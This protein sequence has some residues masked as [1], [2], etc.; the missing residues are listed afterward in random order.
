MSPLTA[1]TST[2]AKSD[3][4]TSALAGGAEKN[5]EP[6]SSAVTATVTTLSNLRKEASGGRVDQLTFFTAS[7]IVI[8]AGKGGVGKTTVSAGLAMA[9]AQIGLRVL[10]VELDE[11]PGA[12][13]IFGCSTP[14]GYG[15]TEI[16]LI[17]PQYG[18]GHIWAQRITASDA[19]TDYLDNHG[20]GR[21][22]RRL[23]SSGIVDIV[24]TAAPGIDDLLVLGKIKALE[25]EG[26]AD[27][28]VVDGPAAGHAISMLMAPRALH[29]SVSGGPIHQQAQEILELLG[30]ESRCQVMLVTL[31]ETTPVSELI[32]TA[33]ALEDEVG[34][35]LAPLVINS[36]EEH[37]VLTIPESLDPKSGLVLAAQF[38]NS[39]VRL[40][41]QEITRLAESI[42]LPTL[43]LPFFSSTRCDVIAAS[44]LHQI[45]LLP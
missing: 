10:F 41:T 8:V 12:E 7:R 32:D 4:E 22:R 39:R 11:K 14:I 37:G 25:R 21:V 23:M 19:L 27:L 3:A 16:D 29:K 44:L 28:I 1:T 2:G 9:A 35:R 34:V 24:A 30:D 43:T 36:V 26:A 42:A 40:Q 6:N 31:P 33:F 5:I 15:P 45:R 13:R 20:L 38:H 18:T 17:N